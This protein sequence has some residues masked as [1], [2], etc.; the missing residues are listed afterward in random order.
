MP[1]ARIQTVSAREMFPH[2]LDISENP[3][4]PRPPPPP[5]SIHSPV[6]L[7]PPFLCLSFLSFP[8]CL[9]TFTNEFKMSG[10]GFLA[11][12]GRFLPKK[13]FSEQMVQY[14][15]AHAYISFCQRHHIPVTFN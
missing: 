15:S 12:Q 3:P 2:K 6:T 13:N 14:E 1:T 11:S 10:T 8:F 4:V 7:L 9:G 5:P